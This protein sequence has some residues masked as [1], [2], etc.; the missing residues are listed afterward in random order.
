MEA[1]WRVPIAD[2]ENVGNALWNSQRATEERSKQGYEELYRVLE[3]SYR[4]FI[5]NES[6]TIIDLDEDD[7]R[8]LEGLEGDELY[9]RSGELR[10]EKLRVGQ[11][12]TNYLGALGLFETRRGFLCETGFVGFG[13]MTMQIGDLIC[14]IFGAEVP[15]A[16]R[17]LGNDRYLFI[18]EVYCDG[19]MDGEAL[20]WGREERTFYL[21]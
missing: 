1:F 6:C 8:Q 17:P 10:G 12:G 3:L 18:G 2:H 7:K 11:L 9:L 21:C 13:P 16:L 15:V 5:N 14:V 4:I 19:A 20:Q